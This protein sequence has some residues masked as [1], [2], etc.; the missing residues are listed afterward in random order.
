MESPVLPKRL[1]RFGLFQ[2]DRES[3]VLLRRGAPVK[4]QD[5]PLRVLCLLL[6]RPGQVVTREELR[7][8]LWPEGTYVEFDG[9]L[10]AA[11]KRLRSALGDNA[12]SPVFIETLPKRGYRFVA[13]VAVETEIQTLSKQS[14]VPV[15]PQLAI[16]ESTVQRPESRRPIERSFIYA[17]AIAT[18]LVGGVGWYGLHYHS[19]AVHS[20][21]SKPAQ[22]FPI[23]RSV[24]VLGFHN[25]SGRPQD[26]WL[27]TAI[28]EMLS[29]ELATGETLRVVSS[30]EVA[31]LRI[32]T[33]W[34]QTGTLGRETTARI[35]TAL[36]SDVLVLG[37][38]AAVGPVDHS[39]L[40]FDVSLQA[41]RTGEVL[42]QIA[43]T[44]SVNDL[45]RFTSEIGARLRQQLGV[46]EIKDAEQAEMLASVPLDRDGARFYALG[47]S[48]LQ[49]FDPVAAKDL[50]EQAVR[51][52]P[53]FSLA[54]L[55]LSRAWAQLGYEQKRKEEAKKALDLSNDLPRSERM[56]VEGDYY[57][58]QANHEKAA[59]T[60]RVLFALFPD[61]VEYGLQL[62]QA[63]YMAGHSSQTIETTLRL[64]SLP[65]PGSNDPRIDLLEARASTASVPARLTLI[66]TAQQKAVAQGKKLVY[67]LARKEECAE[68][69]SSDHT[70]QALPACQDAYG[71]FLATGNRLAAADTIG[72]MASVE[73]SL[74]HPDQAI[75]DFERALEMLREFGEDEKTGSV[76]NNMAIIYTNRG[77]LDRAEQLYR[78]ARFHFEQ[79]GDKR[80][81][82]A[83]LADL[84][85]ILYLSG[86]LPAAGNSYQ[87]A[88]EI[89][90]SLDD[91]KP[92]Y[93]QYRL[94]DLELARGHVQ[95]AHRLAQQAL[96]GITP[97]Q[98]DY[99]HL[100]EALVQMG[101]VFR[102]EG[103]LSGA[104][105]QFEKAR[106]TEL[107]AGDTGLL[108]ESQLELADLDLDE[109]RL[110]EA[111]SL[112]RPA[113]VEFQKEQSGPALAGAYSELSQ[114]FLQQGKLEDAQD[115]AQRA[116][117]FVLSTPDPAMRLPIAAQAARVEAALGQNA[118]EPAESAAAIAKFRSVIAAARK[119]GYYNLECQAR[120]DLGKTELKVNP[121]IGRSQ[122]Q[123]LERETHE[124]GLE[125]ISHKAQTLINDN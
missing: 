44:G 56:Q 77:E 21:R 108:E 78:Q 74:A 93:A 118:S 33:P 46:P 10:N 124:H 6:E 53:K 99:G 80:H 13:P 98:G 54:H 89:T 102:A 88:I 9:S 38:Y 31:N 81:T 91:G 119:L 3:G 34:S 26:D 47:V 61:N 20:S 121:A 100:T 120:L 84:G 4:I 30:E 75:S 52:D 41:A 23:R 107:K 36:N 97:I 14:G 51:A 105:K 113:I 87:Q 112:I 11:L 40:R 69:N 35:G 67:A 92:G 104:R 101:E 27:G 123:D 111:E 5:Q 29:T 8:K 114:F 37:S 48:K 83:T 43:Q 116:G 110:Q 72:S 24:A 86:N 59:S 90:A 62:G 55:M 125:Y 28:S 32:S 103:D 63:Q 15:L 58:S 7:Q 25:A 66:R 109:G 117:K 70:D 60:Y 22:S 18:I 57:E 95:N 85:D 82:A 68:L 2:V 45:F 19:W 115:A 64:R 42:G 49:E 1:Y 79:A 71:V 12:E 106:N 94:S 39:Q 16:P 17:L 73:A 122:L 76:L 65:P 50:L 96:D